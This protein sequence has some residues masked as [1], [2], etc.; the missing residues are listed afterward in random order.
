MN[1]AGTFKQ[2]ALTLRAFGECVGSA[3]ITP[4]VV[5]AASRPLEYADLQLQCS[6]SRLRRF[7]GQEEKLLA[8]VG[9][10]LASADQGWIAFT[11]DGRWSE[12]R[13]GAQPPEL[14]AL[15]GGAGVKRNWRG[16]LLREGAAA[17]CESTGLVLCI[18]RQALRGGSDCAIWLKLGGVPF[19]VSPCH[20][21]DIHVAG[22]ERA[23]L[24]DAAV[25]AGLRLEVMDFPLSPIGE[26][27]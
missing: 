2:Q 9:A 19:R 14:A 8:F 20:H 26:L 11:C 7:L 22:L 25:F 15:L 12:A 10:L 5:A 13:A 4:H 17:V 1:R 21:A 6:E 18:A 23:S 27:D 3:G 16:A 24:E